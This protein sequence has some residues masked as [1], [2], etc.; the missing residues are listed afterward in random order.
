MV[1]IIVGAGVQSFINFQNAV[2]GALVVFKEA[3]EIEGSQ[4]C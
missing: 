1:L 4:I 3:S 2:K